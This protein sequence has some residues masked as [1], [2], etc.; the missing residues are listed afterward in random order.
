MWFRAKK[1]SNLRTDVAKD[2]DIVIEITPLDI[3]N[4]TGAS[5][6]G[7][8]FRLLCR[9][10]GGGIEEGWI[11]NDPERIEQAEEPPRA[12]IKV[13]EFLRTCVDAEVWMNNLEETNPHFVLADFLVA[14]SLIETGMTNA[15]SAD[16][17]SGGLGPFQIGTGSWAE[18]VAGPGGADFGPAD[19]D[20]YLNQCYC[21]AFLTQ[22]DIRFVSDAISGSGLSETGEIGAG[23]EPFVP[24]LVDVLLAWITNS[25]AAAEFRVLKIKNQGNV[26][27]D[28]VLTRH[29]AGTTDE[30]RKAWLEAVAL[31]RGDFLRRSAAM[32][33]TTD[34]MYAKLENRLAKELTAAF[35]L[36]KKHI[37]EDIPQASDPSGWMAIAEAE[38]KI[39][40]EKGLVENADDGASKVINYFKATDSGITSVQHWCGAFVAHCLA[41]SAQPVPPV[42]G[43]ARAANWKV[44]GTSVP[45]GMADYPRGAVVVLSPAPG[46]ET[47]GH[48]AFFSSFLEGAGNPQIELLGGN[49]RDTVRLSKFARTKVVAVRMPPVT[50]SVTVS[51]PAGEA[52]SG[53]FAPLLEL[54]S[55]FE[56]GKN[57]NARF[58]K[59]D[60][61]NPRFV[62][63]TLSEVLK[64]QSDFVNNGSPSSAVGRYQIIQG[65]LRG[66]KDK[67][68]L[69]GTERFDAAL[70]DRLAMQLLKG[71]KLESFLSKSISVTRFGLFLAME[72]AS[73]PVLAATKG[74]HMNVVRRQSFYAGD[75][76]NNA[77]IEPEEVEKV[78]KALI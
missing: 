62:E 53:K 46:S 12:E 24:S 37:P 30:E 65:T 16:E 75:G 1:L 64:W 14:L 48:V 27:V 29:A 57:Y 69:N 36:M 77:H 26:K 71:R 4:Q 60:N 55:R 5:D 68:D 40:R 38:E 21:A 59:I 76:L 19:R 61:Q 13:T 20:D 50:L 7:S 2:S 3:C 58:K 31:R 67:L 54:I 72:W 39:W 28:E 18:F 73:L 51:L 9:I 74:A 78:L 32:F 43:S 17:G 42:S 15:P 22:R 47:S 11:D 6:D 41:G 70:Q 44:W 45:L 33:E 56:G 10:N 8:R 34:G 35:K 23:S 52:Q 25:A 49:Q 66:L 63:M